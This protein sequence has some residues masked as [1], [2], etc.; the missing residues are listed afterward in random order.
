MFLVEW[1]YS[2]EIALVV[3]V[4]LF[5]LLI[6]KCGWVWTLIRLILKILG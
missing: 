6:V 5:V 2:D 1:F 4:I 3:L